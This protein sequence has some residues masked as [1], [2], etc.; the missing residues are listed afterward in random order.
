[1]YHC[2]MTPY[3]GYSDYI[4]VSY[5]HK[6]ADRV[7]PIVDALAER[8]YRIWYDEGIIPGSEWPEYIAEHLHGSCIILAFIS[9]ASIQSD[10]C[11]REITFALSKKINLLGIILEPVEMSLGLEMQLA[12]HQCVVKYKYPS[13]TQFIDK[14]CSMPEL[15]TCIRFSN[16]KHLRQK[17]VADAHKVQSKTQPRNSIN[18]PTANIS[19]ATKNLTQ[20][21]RTAPAPTPALD[22]QT[23]PTGKVI[24]IL[25]VIIALALVSAAALLYSAEKEPPLPLPE[26]TSIPSTVQTF[27]PIPTES[28]SPISTP[29]PTPVVTL[30][31]QLPEVTPNVYIPEITYTPE[32]VIT[33][34]P[35]VPDNLPDSPPDSPDEEPRNDD[36]FILPDEQTSEIEEEIPSIVIEVPTPAEIYTNE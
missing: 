22:P 13:F 19:S 23:D 9:Q 18:V 1:M 17:Q 12:A 32:P 36:P 6:D 15:E 2:K 30:S 21:T 8:G 4:F 24:A 28:F 33:E 20:P 34:T 7:L 27:F 29:I 11:R 25:V 3:E 10:N 35:I 16:G 31:P 14:I 5:A 26:N